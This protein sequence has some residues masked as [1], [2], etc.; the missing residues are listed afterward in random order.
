[1]PRRTRTERWET[2]GRSTRTISYPPTNVL[3]SPLP[4]KKPALRA[5]FSADLTAGGP[6]NC[7][8]CG[9]DS[10]PSADTHIRF[11]S[12]LSTLRVKAGSEEL[13]LVTL[14]RYFPC[15]IVTENELAGDQDSRS[16]V[17][18]ILDM[19]IHMLVTSVANAVTQTA[20][21]PALTQVTTA[22][23]HRSAGQQPPTALAHPLPFLK[24]SGMQALCHFGIGF[25]QLNICCCSPPVPGSP[26]CHQHPGSV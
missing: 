14:W 9:R 11:P 26:H 2:Q 3:T 21:R 25:H 17:M 19:L 23:Q 16:G 24:L 22:V 6:R 7:L 20:V 10:P 18:G 5:P 12:L 13:Y 8:L 15:A 1:M 4:W